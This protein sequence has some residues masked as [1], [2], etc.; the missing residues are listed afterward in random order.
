MVNSPALRN[1][2]QAASAQDSKPPIP[3]Y[4]LD[5]T[6]ASALVSRIGDG[7]PARL[8]CRLYENRQANITAFSIQ[9]QSNHHL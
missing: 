1:Y 3:L 5:G 4:G 6:Y 2:A 9:L 8:L 7:R